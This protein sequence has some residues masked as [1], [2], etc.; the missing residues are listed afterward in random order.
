M[1]KGRRQ[2]MVGRARVE[3][4]QS[5]L[6]KRG[7]CKVKLGG[8]KER[9]GDRRQGGCG[10]WIECGV[11]VDS[12]GVGVVVEKSVAIQKGFRHAW[13]TRVMH[14][15]MKS[16]R[17]KPNQHDTHIRQEINTDSIKTKTI[18][19]YTTNNIQICTRATYS[20]FIILLAYIHCTI[21]ITHHLF[22]SFDTLNWSTS[23]LAYHPSSLKHLI[24][25]PPN[26][27]SSSLLAS[28]TASS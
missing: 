4:R 15:W 3:Y 26:I 19:K 17:H 18:Y 5:E 7:V 2:V 9:C 11:G 24:W 6:Q 28:H 23:S 27:A 16:P 8:W 13:G 25:L 10:V 1:F 14:S 20:N 21:Y 22:P 12:V